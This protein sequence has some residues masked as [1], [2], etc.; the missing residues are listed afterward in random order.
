MQWHYLP[1]REVLSEA[2]DSLCHNDRWMHCWPYPRRAP[3]YVATYFAP[4]TV[5]VTLHVLFL[6]W[7]I[8]C[9]ARNEY[10]QYCVRDLVSY[11]LSWT[12]ICGSGHTKKVT[13]NAMI[14]ITYCVSN[15][16]APQFFLAT[17]A[18]L[19]VLGM[20]AILGS[21]VLS[22]FSAILYGAYCFYEN[23]RRDRLDL[24]AHERV[25]QDTDFKDLTDKQ[26]IHFRY[27]W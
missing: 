8:H 13:V 21:Y 15:I 3:V 6:P 23:K 11:D 20:S 18:P 19:Y 27:V 26:N 12:N 16:V 7:T 24:A 17:Q 22:I 10:S 25:H 4:L 14:F 1:C 2:P 9:V 5:G